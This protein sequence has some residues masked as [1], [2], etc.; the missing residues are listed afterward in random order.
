LTASSGSTWRYEGSSGNLKSELKKRREAYLGIP[1][2]SKLSQDDTTGF[3]QQPHVSSDH[4]YPSRHLP[5]Y[6]KELPSLPSLS[7]QGLQSVKTGDSV[8]VKKEAS[9]PQ[10]ALDQSQSTKENTDM[11]SQLAALRVPIRRRNE[12]CLPTTPKPDDEEAPLLQ[13]TKG[14]GEEKAH[15]PF[16][17]I[18]PY[19]HSGQPKKKILYGPDGYLGKKPDWKQSNLQKMTEK[20]E[21]LGSRV[22]SIPSCNAI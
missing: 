15:V 14:T 17:P 4:V 9:S 21:S 8:G 3:K 11:Y 2:N 7:E 6:E 13:H 19:H 22:V 1:G 16:D 18:D 20:V 10:Y 12:P 5:V